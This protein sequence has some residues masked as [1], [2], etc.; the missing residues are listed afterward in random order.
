LSLLSAGD[1]ADGCLDKLTAMAT[2]ATPED[3]RRCSPWPFPSPRPSP[4]GRRGLR[5]ALRAIFMVRQACWRTSA[6]SLRR[7]SRGKP[8]S[9]GREVKA[10]VTGVLVCS[11]DA[12]CGV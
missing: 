8:P 2:S 7:G 10:A 6:M 12:L 4:R 11:G 5:S 9:T 3:E 1:T